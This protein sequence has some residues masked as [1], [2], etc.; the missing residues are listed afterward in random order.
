MK[1]HLR[2]VTV[3]GNGIHTESGKIKCPDD[4]FQ[5]LKAQFGSET[6]EQAHTKNKISKFNFI[7]AGP[8]AIKRPTRDE[9]F[10]PLK[11][12]KVPPGAFSFIGIADG[13]VGMRQFSCWCRQCCQVEGRGQ[14]GMDAMLKVSG[15]ALCDQECHQWKE[16]G[17]SKTATADVAQRRSSA[18]TR[19]QVVARNL[20]VGQWVA[21]Q[22]RNDDKQTYWVGKAVDAGDGSPIVKHFQ[23]GGG[24]GKLQNVTFTEGDYAIAV[25][26]YELCA[27]DSEE[28][29]FQL[30]RE[31]QDVCNST[32]LH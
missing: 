26:W 9:Q 2:T 23:R 7:W 13:V 8:T 22:S 21:M 5:Q 31:H 17:V 11:G 10:E 16:R 30:E 24:G 14:G 1:N 25:Q 3:D 27:E 12:M 32:E 19:G 6:W 4:V 29:T 28:L 15:C 20:K 18:Q